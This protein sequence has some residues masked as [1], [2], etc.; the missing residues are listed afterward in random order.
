MLSGP[1]AEWIAEFKVLQASPLIPDLKKNLAP[2]YFMDT[3]LAEVKIERIY[4]N[5]SATQE[6]AKEADNN[7]LIAKPFKSNAED[8]SGIRFLYKNAPFTN[9][10]LRVGEIKTIFLLTSVVEYAKSNNM[11]G[12]FQ[13]DRQHNQECPKALYRIQDE[14]VTVENNNYINV[15]VLQFLQNKVK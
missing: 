6:T 10:P 8:E 14:I 12:F 1:I 4:K 13:N 11:I 7:A 15:N 3:S 2:T 9:A 5:S